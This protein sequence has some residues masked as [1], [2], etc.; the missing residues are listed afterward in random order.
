MKIALVTHDF[1]GG[2]GTMTRFLYQ[3]LVN[4]SPY[5]VD[6]VLLPTYSFDT[7]SMRLSAP[8]SWLHAP[9]VIDG[10]AGDI[11]YRRVGVAF[12]ELEFQRYRPRPILTQLL[13][14]YDLV[15]VVSGSPVFGL[16]TQGLTTPKCIFAATTLHEERRTLLAAER[17]WRRLWKVAMTRVCTRLERA[18][19]RLMDCVF[20]ESEYTRRLL[21]PYVT[22]S[23]LRLGLPGVDTH[24]FIPQDSE[25]TTHEPYLLAVGRFADPRKNVRLLLAA[26]AR[27][28]A[29]SAAAP[30]LV[31]AGSTPLPDAAWHYAELLGIRA[32]VVNLVGVAQGEL[33]RL[34]R[35]ATLFVLSSDEEGLGIVILEA[36]ACG[37]PVVSTACGG[38]ATAIVPEVTGLLTPVGDAAALA[39]AMQTL[40]ER[41]ARAR[42]LGMAGR[43]RVEA[44]FSLAHAGRVYLDAYH[45]LLAHTT[46]A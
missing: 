38:P 19:L 32:R 44:H 39:H 20:A 28:C 26:Y 2:I 21:A 12:S 6:V 13:Q 17:G 27:L 37:L 22:P 43:R 25:T 36:M 34:Y 1:T 11:P 40:L 8:Q 5:Q 29:T 14:Q 4:F 33:V 10:M 31:L 16:V 41:P 23:A 18:A 45:A 7:A 15:Q 46:N 24:L 35:H 3:V 42:A 30:K 9:K